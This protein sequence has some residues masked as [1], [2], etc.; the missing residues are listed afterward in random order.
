MISIISESGIPES[1]QSQIKSQKSDSILKRKS[2]GGNDVQLQK[3]DSTSAL[4]K[5][6]ESVRSVGARPSRT[7]KLSFGGGFYFQLIDQK[8]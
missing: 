1:R 8:N 5:R 7:S 3:S 6:A 4:Q 2:Q